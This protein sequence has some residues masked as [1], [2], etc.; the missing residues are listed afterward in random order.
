MGR[1]SPTKTSPLHDVSREHESRYSS[2]VARNGDIV[3][4]EVVGEGVILVWGGRQQ[5]V[6]RRAEVVS[7]RITAGQAEW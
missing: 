7:A 3:W 1:H 4:R 5:V 6:R 2:V